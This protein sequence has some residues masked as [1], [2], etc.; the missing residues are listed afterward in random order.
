MGEVER[1]TKT[2]IGTVREI[3]MEREREIGKAEK[4]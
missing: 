4:E 3:N 1:D 2:D